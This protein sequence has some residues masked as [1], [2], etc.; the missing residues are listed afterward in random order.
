MM[1]EDR[2][3]NENGPRVE[4]RPLFEEACDRV[5][6]RDQADEMSLLGLVD[7]VI[8]RVIRDMG[9]E[10]AE[11]SLRFLPI[12]TQLANIRQQIR[13]EVPRRDGRLRKAVASMMR[14]CV[15]ERGDERED[16]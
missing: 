1:D 2:I 7:E 15:L 6:D 11:D 16:D 8:T 4:R 5:G 3:P 14:D 12:L 10:S 9:E 13:F